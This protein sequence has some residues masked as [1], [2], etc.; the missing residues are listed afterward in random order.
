MKNEKKM[1]MV[2]VDKKTK[3]GV[4]LRYKVRSRGSGQRSDDT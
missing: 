4:L 3:R 2:V 1:E